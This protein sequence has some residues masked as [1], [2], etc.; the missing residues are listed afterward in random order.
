MSVFDKYKQTSVFSKYQPLEEEDGFDIGK[1]I[2]GVKT[3]YSGLAQRIG[4]G[5]KDQFN[6]GQ[7]I[8]VRGQGK[9]KEGKYLQGGLDIATGIVKST[10]SPAIGTQAGLVQPAIEDLTNNLPPLI[11]NKLKEKLGEAEGKKAYRKL[12]EKLKGDFTKVKEA[13]DSSPDYVKSILDTV[14]VGLDVAGLGIGGKVAK[15]GVDVAGEAI[16]QGAKSLG[17]SVGG[18]AVPAIKSALDTGI[19]SIPAI[20]RGA[21]DLIDSGVQKTGSLLAG[22]RAEGPMKWVAKRDSSSLATELMRQPTKK[23]DPFANKNFFGKEVLDSYDQSVVDELAKVPEFNQAR[24]LN[25]EIDYKKAKDILRNNIEKSSKDIETGLALAKREGMAKLED[26]TIARVPKKILYEQGDIEELTTKF[27]DNVEL[28]KNATN[29]INRIYNSIYNANGKVFPKVKEYLKYLDTNLKENLK[30]GSNG[31]DD[32]YRAIKDSD[33]VLENSG[34]DIG[35]PNSAKLKD[36]VSRAWSQTAREKVKEMALDSDMPI[37]YVQKMDSLSKIMSARDMANV[38]GHNPDITLYN[39][40]N[41][42]VRK[43]Y[44]ATGAAGIAGFAAGLPTL[45]TIGTWTGLGYVG[46]SFGKYMKNGLRKMNG[47]LLDA[48][49][50]AHLKTA[51][52]KNLDEIISLQKQVEGAIGNLE[53]EGVKTVRGARVPVTPESAYING[54]YLNEVKAGKSFSEGLQN[55]TP[56]LPEGSSTQLGSGNTGN[57]YMKPQLQP[58]YGLR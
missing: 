56:L 26:G 40:A 27:F 7:D 36:I 38:H 58:E 50:K 57:P 37:E 16:T 55:K 15:A 46:Y 49:K 21:G 19:K 10:I 4:G 28:S 48:I 30:K 33:Q 44:V 32:F 51:S 25:G 3:A 12:S 11:E 45:A 17:D 6:K 35:D 2:E 14:G 31:L 24:K 29:P 34:V 22:T 52:I 18:A 23:L 42:F 1:G 43:N 9:I 41:E 53:S 13:Y 47:V 39:K 20:K 54:D 5:I 8:V